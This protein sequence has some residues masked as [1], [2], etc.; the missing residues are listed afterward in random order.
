ASTTLEPVV[1]ASAETPSARRAA[2]GRIPELDGLRGIAICLVLGAHF[3]NVTNG[4]RLAAFFQDLFLLG[5]SGVDL[6]FVLSEF[7]IG[8]I[9]LDVRSSHSYFKTFYA[10][11]FFRIIPIYYLWVTLYLLLV[12]LGSSFLRAHTRSGTVPPLGFDIYAHYLFLQNFAV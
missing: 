1:S 2:P 3:I 11:R 8:G 7:L 9:L 5:W 4:P 12:G 6:F 10:R